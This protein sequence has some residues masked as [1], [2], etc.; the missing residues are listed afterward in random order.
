[1]F[2]SWFSR[3]CACLRVRLA[4]WFAA[5]RPVHSRISVSLCCICMS[6]GGGDTTST[7]MP[8]PVPPRTAVSR[9]APSAT[10]LRLD[11]LEIV[12]NGRFIVASLRRLVAHA[13][14]G[15]VAAARPDHS[16]ISVSLCCN[17]MIEGVGDTTSTAMPVPPRT[18]VSRF[19]SSATA[20]RLDVFEIVGN[21]RFM[22]ACLPRLV[23]RAVYEM[24]CGGSAGSELDQRLVV[25]LLH[26][27]WGWVHLIDGDV[28]AAA[29]VGEV[30]SGE[31]A[32][33]VL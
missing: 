7:A 25:L 11:V 21:V 8:R 1:M 10:A 5:P 31:R 28:E 19:A 2:A 29:D 4:A 33:P 15:R 32:N 24:G 14:R 30:R 12:G 3:C 22:V 13:V 20:L 23:A 16:W 9:F 17:C 27:R 18:A 26:E 6:D